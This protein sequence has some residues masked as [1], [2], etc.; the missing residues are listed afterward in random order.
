MPQH[1]TDILLEFAYQDMSKESQRRPPALLQKNTFLKPIPS[2]ANYITCKLNGNLSARELTVFLLNRHN[3]LVRDVSGK[4]G[5]A[6][7]YLRVAV[8]TPEENARL[9]SA[10]RGY[11]E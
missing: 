1:Q 9:I 7:E 10:L 3:I 8:K 4:N 5:V 2:R 6:G 11:V